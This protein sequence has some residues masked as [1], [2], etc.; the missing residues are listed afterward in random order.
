M[1]PTTGIFFVN[2]QN[3]S[4]VG[5]TERK[6]PTVTDSFEAP[7][8]NHP[9]DRASVNGAGPFFTFSAPLSGQY[10]ERGQPVGPS[11]P[12]SAAM[13]PAHRGQCP[14][15]P[16]RMGVSARRQRPLAGGKASRR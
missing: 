16:S 11:L 2:A 15:R 1:D 5:R 12:A 4:L 13:V 14:H 9:F 6:P 10:N 8:S 7:N 3:T